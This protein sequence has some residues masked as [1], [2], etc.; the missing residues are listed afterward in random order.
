MNIWRLIVN[1][2]WYNIDTISLDKIARYIYILI[3]V[4]AVESLYIDSTIVHQHPGSSESYFP[5]GHRWPFCYLR[6]HPVFQIFPNWNHSIPFPA[7]RARFSAK[8]NQAKLVLLLYSFSL[9]VWERDDDDAVFMITLFCR[10][11]LHLK[12]PLSSGCIQISPD[13]VNYTIRTVQFGEK[14]VVFTYRLILLR[15]STK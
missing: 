4:H 9:D 6:H 13:K 10:L 2:K 12:E 1:K 11:E 8:S 14:G 5:P 15:H 7:D 3:I